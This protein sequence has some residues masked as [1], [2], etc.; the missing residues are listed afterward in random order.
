M[1]R[2]GK[3]AAART[4]QLWITIRI[5]RAGGVVVW[6]APGAWLLPVHNGGTNREFELPWPEFPPSGWNEPNETLAQ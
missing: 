3:G 2:G 4:F 6:A 1:K 5:Q